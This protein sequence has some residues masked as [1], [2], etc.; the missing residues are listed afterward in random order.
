MSAGKR[1]FFPLWE[2]QQQWAKAFWHL[3]R[4]AVE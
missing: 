1:F 4:R 3:S 2:L